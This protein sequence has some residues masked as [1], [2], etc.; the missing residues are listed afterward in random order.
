MKINNEKRYVDGVLKDDYYWIDI[1]RI[2]LTR[3]E[4][5]AVAEYVKENNII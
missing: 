2:L 5:I 4:M 1:S 3:K